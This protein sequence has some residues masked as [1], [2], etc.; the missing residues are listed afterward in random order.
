LILSDLKRHFKS[1][2]TWLLIWLI[3]LLSYVQVDKIKAERINR[4]FSGKHNI[5]MESL[6]I[7]MQGSKYW[8]N[9]VNEYTNKKRV[10][11]AQKIIKA[12]AEEDYESYNKYKTLYNLIYAKMYMSSTDKILSKAA[13]IE[14]KKLWHK[15]SDG[16]DFEDIDTFYFRHQAYLTEFFYIYKAK[17][18]HYL[19]KHGLEEVYKDD[20]N[21]LSFL[22]RYLIDVLPMLLLI[23]PVLLTYN[24]ISREVNNGSIKLL[25]TQGLSRWKYY[26]SKY[27]SGILY[28]LFLVYIPL[29]FISA[30]IGYKYSFVSLK[31]PVFYYPIGFKSLSPRYNFVEGLS[32]PY[33]YIGISRL[34][35]QHIRGFETILLGDEII[36]F[37]KFLG[38]AIFFTI[39]F[40][41]FAVA[42]VELVS[43]LL[44]NEILSFALLAVIFALGYKVSQPF[45]HGK[46]YNLSPFTMNNPVTIINGSCN[47][48]AL[49]SLLILAFSTIALL[50]TGILYFNKR[51]I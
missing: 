43:A 34:P 7:R 16:I 49:T 19:Y 9:L 39:L 25:L 32:E 4:Q 11:I 41:M 27:I 45:I 38:L 44:D 12:E 40:L 42:L 3:L 20:I 10:E 2:I 51:N 13:E 50:A 33:V 46:H 31:Y 18:Y 47:V 8:T 21:N 28:I 5:E 14:I 29:I 37:Y 26:I 23:L 6:D 17:F 24:T 1:P 35:K 22:Y 15:A 48:T 36:A 30:M